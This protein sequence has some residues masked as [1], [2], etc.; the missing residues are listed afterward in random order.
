[1]VQDKQGHRV[2]FTIIL[3]IH[4]LTIINGIGGKTSLLQVVLIYL[5]FAFTIPDAFYSL[6]KFKVVLE[7]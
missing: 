2:G 3:T 5:I 6:T 7:I 4:S 1:M